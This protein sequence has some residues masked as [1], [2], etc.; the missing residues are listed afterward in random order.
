MSK[1]RLDADT[2]E[3]AVLGGAVLGGGGGG[4]MALGRRNGLLAVELGAPELVDLDDVVP[5]AV[6]VTVS[7]VGSPAATTA[8]TLRMHYVRA[9][10]LIREQGGT[11]LDGLITTECGALATVNGWLQAAVLGLPVVDAPCNGRAHPTGLMGSIGLHRVEGYVSTQAA[12]GGASAAGRYLELVARGSLERTASLVL[13]ASVQAGG[14][15]AV[16]RNPVAA[17]YARD[18]AAPGAIRQSIAVGR[19]MLERRDDGPAAM[20]EAVCAALRGEVAA[21]GRVADVQLET[22]G[23]LDVGTVRVQMDDRQLAELGFWNEYVSLDLADADGANPRRIA[24][25]PDLLVT[26]DASSGL[27]LSSAEVAVGQEVAV[28]RVDRRHLILGAGMRD[29]ALLRTI[30]EA[31]GRDVVRYVFP[32]PQQ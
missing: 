28:V 29:P 7:A 32:N 8:Y 5:E 21:R 10:E 4:S 3:A 17:S 25:F 16:A 23:G 26:L 27:P 11:A 14:M 1:I 6:L 9:V 24:T 13:Q 19:S 12:A 30:E 31:T 2:V 18:H 20:I 15:V 22:D